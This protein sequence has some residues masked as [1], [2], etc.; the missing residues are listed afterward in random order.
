MIDLSTRWLGLSL[1]GPIVASSSP[2][3][4]HLDNA[5][6]LEDAGAAAIVM[7]SLFEEQIQIE[8]HTLDRHLTETAEGYAEALSYFPEMGD[9]NLGPEGYVEHLH[10][11]KQSVAIPVIGSLNGISS[12][13]WIDYARRI[14]QAG[15]DALELN[16]Y[17][18]P[19]DPNESGATVEAMYCDLVRDVTAVVK[20][21]VSVKIGARLTAPVHVA[22]QLVAAGARG[23]T[24]FN[25]FYQPD[26]DLEHLE[27]IPNVRLSTSD[28]LRLRLR[29]VA[30]M[31]GHI[32]GDLAITGG[33]HTAPDVIK[34]MMA[35]ANVAMMTSA[36]LK[37]GIEHLPRVLAELREW[38]ELREYESIGQMQGS[39]SQRNV[40]QPAAFERAQYLRVLRS[41]HTWH[42]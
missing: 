33:V 34:C 1:K 11:V 9:Y 2:L 32:R 23:L 42:R 28:E 13:G 36:L 39:M 31:Y 27:V 25:R 24:L 18:L 22:R 15:A 3:T 40:H 35:G 8:S 29:W 4:E 16:V 5:R 7:H 41:Y 37:Q 6:R 19:T 12:G 30:I 21:P 38:M 14:E 26:F 10:R 20:I 17:F